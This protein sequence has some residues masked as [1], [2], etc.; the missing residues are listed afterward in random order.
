MSNLKSKLLLFLGVLY[1]F[2]LLNLTI[3]GYL[4]LFQETKCFGK[5]KG[6]II[7]YGESWAPSALQ[8]INGINILWVFDNNDCFDKNCL[9]I[10]S[11]I[12]ENNEKDIN[13][14]KDTIRNSGVELNSFM[15]TPIK[16][17]KMWNGRQNE[18]LNSVDIEIKYEETLGEYHCV[19]SNID[20]YA[21]SWVDVDSKTGYHMVYPEM[22]QTSKKAVFYSC[23]FTLF[24]LKCKELKTFPFFVSYVVG[25]III[26]FLAI[27][28]IFDDKMKF[29][30][31]LSLDF[32]GFKVGCID[33]CNPLNGSYSEFDIGEKYTVLNGSTFTPLA[34]T[35]RG[36]KDSVKTKNFFLTFEEENLFSIY[37]VKK[38]EC[39]RTVQ[40]SNEK[41]EKTKYFLHLLNLNEKNW[42]LNNIRN[43]HVSMAD[44]LSEYIDNPNGDLNFGEFQ[45]KNIA[46]GLKFLN[47]I[48]KFSKSNKRI[49][50][51]L[52]EH[53]KLFF[54]DL[55]LSALT[56]VIKKRTSWS[57]K[58][59]SV[60]NCQWKRYVNDVY[61]LNQIIGRPLFF[62][63]YSKPP[64]FT[65][66]MKKSIEFVS[67]LDNN[68]VQDLKDSELLGLK[69]DF[70]PNLI[71]DID[72]KYYEKLYENVKK[73]FL[74]PDSENEGTEGLKNIEEIKEKIDFLRKEK[75]EKEKI[76]EIGQ[77]ANK[78]PSAEIIHL[79]AGL[80]KSSEEVSKQRLER[81]M[82]KSIHKKEKTS[83]RIE[84]D[85]KGEREREKEKEK[86]IRNKNRDKILQLNKEIRDLERETQNIIRNK[87][88]LTEKE[89][90]RGILTNL[91][92]KKA[93]LSDFKKSEGVALNKI[94][95]KKIVEDINEGF[96][97][98][99]FFKVKE[100][101]GGGKNEKF[102]KE[103]KR[104]K[105]EMGDKEE[106][107][108]HKN[109]KQ[110][111]TNYY[112]ILRS[113]KEEK[114]EDG[115]SSSIVE[116]KSA[117]G[118]KKDE[119]NM[120][121]LSKKERAKLQKKKEKEERSKKEKEKGK[122]KGKEKGKGGGGKEK[123]YIMD[124]NL[125]AR[126][127]K[128]AKECLTEL[129]NNFISDINN[130]DNKK[131]EKEESD[132]KGKK[133]KVD[134]IESKKQNQPKYNNINI[135]KI[136]KIKNCFKFKKYI[137]GMVLNSTRITEDRENSELEEIEEMSELKKQI[138]SSKKEKEKRAKVYDE[139]NEEDEKF[140]FDKIKL[141]S[142]ILDKIKSLKLN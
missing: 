34:Q 105:D 27:V 3:Y 87:K 109:L 114:K 15:I 37:S 55:C 139:K 59:K 13:L 128:G 122:G 120:E 110:C 47:F 88:K 130:N 4:K 135:E 84:K 133:E 21:R 112:S 50:R 129:K 69:I 63:Q 102:L 106:E 72:N 12:K 96:I 45:V 82:E 132:R 113:F 22:N 19:S 42:P 77:Y 138:F 25:I 115:E 29:Y 108:L 61:L 60:G 26:S 39:L 71:V 65:E 18:I 136:G 57:Q 7:N 23:T 83:K 40:M 81:K 104:R 90:T 51:L 92:F 75:E 70:D 74:T 14:V 33:F 126:S 1:T 116:M 36:R 31:V 111:S 124:L 118:N 91:D 38:G 93:I 5:T 8:F 121:G 140:S 52:I 86:E 137:F 131:K 53:N 119:I 20:T 2:S 94:N 49:S 117:E 78:S 54:G 95:E 58:P 134:E 11:I 28:M 142:L 99:L 43:H 46:L 89:K 141:K 30:I 48:S 16:S 103:I 127:F 32:F 68:E 97:A 98:P 44:F 35:L 66:A 76:E 56:N 107:S 101:K 6:R 64:D 73:I 10:T 79:Y 9:N 85:E 67:K 80:Y 62:N 41:A 123:Q 125:S 24:E 17:D 100:K